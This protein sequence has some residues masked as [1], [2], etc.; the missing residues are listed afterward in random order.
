MLHLSR[1]YVLLNNS[2]LSGVVVIH[3]VCY[4]NLIFWV[5][6]QVQQQQQQPN[7]TAVLIECFIHFL[8]F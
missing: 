7:K 1:E 2:C 4:E 6:K 8:Y 3:F 5:K